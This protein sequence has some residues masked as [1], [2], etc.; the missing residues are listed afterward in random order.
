VYLH[1]G[2]WSPFQGRHPGPSS[3]PAS[4]WDWWRMGRPA[5]GARGLDGFRDAAREERRLWAPR[6]EVVPIELPAMVEGVGSNG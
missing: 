4:A 6:G 3:C 5:P 2:A 1:L